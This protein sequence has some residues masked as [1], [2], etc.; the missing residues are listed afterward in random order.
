[1]SFLSSIA[2]KLLPSLISEV[3]PELKADI[4]KALNDLQAKAAATPNKID[5]IVVKL[6]RDI[7]QL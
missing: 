3:T 2:E 7:T 6:I 4:S 1:M 5:D